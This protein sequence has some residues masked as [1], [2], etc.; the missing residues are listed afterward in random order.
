MFCFASERE[1][2]LKREPEEQI[3]SFQSRPL[4]RRDLVRRTAKFVSLVKYVKYSVLVRERQRE[5]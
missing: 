3:L 5:R 2:T 4:F 1:P